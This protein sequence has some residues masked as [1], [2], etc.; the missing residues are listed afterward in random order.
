VGE[1]D[2]LGCLR[3]R[4]VDSD[5]MRLG[6]VIYGSLETRSGGY[7]YDRMLVEHMRRHGDQVEVISLPWQ[8]YA[9]HLTHN[10]HPE[11]RRRLS[12]LKVD[13]LLQDE[14][15]HPSLFWLN[16]ALRRQ[17]P[18][19]LVSIVHHLRCREERPVWQ[20]R[21]YGWVEGAYLASLDSFICNSRSTEESV[22][23]LL[24]P[25][26]RDIPA[27]VVSPGGD[28][29]DPQ[30]TDCEIRRRAVE[31]GPLQV[32]F[33]GNL[34]PRKGLHVLLEALSKLERPAWQLMVAGSL[35][36]DRPYA[37]GLI[38]GV[39]AAGL[40]D[41][42]RFLSSINDG[43]LIAWLKRSHVLAVPS[44]YEGF[45]IVYL[46][47]LG[48][49]VPVL[50]SRAGGGVEIVSDGETGYLVSPGDAEGLAARLA[51]LAQDRQR[52]CIMSL[53]ARQRYLTWPTW[54]ETM[55]AARDFLLSM[56]E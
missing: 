45:G 16:R 36:A 46:E 55:Q 26:R 8:G 51:E 53:A 43:E 34:I 50:A 38:R 19:P 17:A 24:P 9:R 54:K 11:L 15:N 14:L 23:E 37:N 42:V 13:L 47:A 39:R 4:P 48:F 20:N 56:V 6:L 29:L 3:A 18:Y 41:N 1:R 22:R 49:G 52:L 25:G 5:C 35:E 21:L 30:V 31:P 40:Q 44:S 10:L 33:V 7:L 32:L 27:Q 2:R 12:R 28:R